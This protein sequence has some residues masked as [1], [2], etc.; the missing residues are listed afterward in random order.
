MLDVDS[1][2]DVLLIKKVYMTGGKDNYIDF[3]PEKPPSNSLSVIYAIDGREYSNS[4]FKNCQLRSCA[5]KR[6]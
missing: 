1:R 5:F 4:Y 2:P 3:K 6:D